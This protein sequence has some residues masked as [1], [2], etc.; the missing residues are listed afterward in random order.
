MRAATGADLSSLLK[1]FRTQAGLSQ[2]MLADRALISVQAVSA[3][4][5]GSR[6]VPYR[7]TLER[8]ADALALSEEARIELEL[9]AKRARGL[10]LEESVVAPPHNLPRQL[11]SFLGRAEV[12]KE[13]VT[14]L[15][16]EPLVS[17]V[18]TGGA[19]K[20]RVAVAVG[21]ALL[22]TFADGVW[23]VD[24]APLSD[25]E[26][27]PQ[28]LASA[29][30]VQESPN[31]PLL[32]TL[33]AYLGQKR[34]LI[35]FDNCEHVMYGT[36]TVVGSLLRGCP[37]LTLLATSREALTLP[38][39]RAYRIPPLAVPREGIPTPEEACRFGAI[40]LFVDRMRAVDS[41][42]VVTTENVEP[43]VDICRR[44][45]GLPLALELAA[46]RTA[47][48]SPSQIRERLDR[49]FDI[50]T[51][52]GAAP[53]P[54]HQTMRA[55][56]DWSY[57][58]LSSQACLLFTRLAI[59]AGGFSLESASAVCCDERLPAA[60]LL[61]LLS[62]LVAQSLIA[63]DFDRGDARYHL[64]EATRQYA[65]QELE[66]HGERTAL[67]ERHLVAFLRV[68]ER[69]DREWYDAPEPSWFRDAEAEVDNFRTALGWSLAERRDLRAGGVLAAAL[70]RVWYSIAPVEGRRWVR[71]AIDSSDNETA[72]DLRARLYIADAELCGS[73][74]EYTAALSA[75]QQALQLCGTLDGLQQA[76]AKQAA[77]SALGGLGRAGEG[78]PLLE[79]AL[80]I[81]QRLDNRRMQALV[82]GDLGTASS[83][84]GDVEGARR[85]YADALAYYEGLN[86]QR[87]AASIAGHLAEV[88]FAAGDAAA[89]LHLAE[90][91]HAAHAAAQNRRAVAN[92]LCNMAAYLIALGCFDDARAYGRQALSVVRDVKQ[93]VLTAYVLQ[94]LAAVAVLRPQPKQRGA[95]A[96]RKRAAMLLGFVDAWLTKLEARR[97]YTERQEYERVM[98]VLSAAISDRLE[99]T[100]AHGAEWT[101]AVAVTVA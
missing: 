32:E 26:F 13:I 50:L 62:S 20:T 15:G 52:N 41:R 21:T 19:G 33:V 55:V 69:L 82:L 48:L 101:E 73:L 97:E 89:A 98:K 22:N 91:A 71:L 94:H 11:T 65:L 45:S 38:G 80:A 36:R 76:R 40:E 24:L 1:R 96:V 7:Y 93:T 74:G 27:V 6:K 92:D 77:G 12:V 31:R 9:S 85:F 67:A 35:V 95:G 18:G 83:R 63:V 53:I 64:L 39:E 44:L 49:I 30:R 8:I 43:I 34:T 25:S 61:A 70:A 23:F 46:A 58:L 10:R 59:F 51:N 28:A 88:E 75:A 100:M 17:I 84:C 81:S 72:H 86:L 37:N 57:G 2:Q 60:D 99:D 5:R 42:A 79:A 54:R 14:L 68:A 3:L 16:Q 4:E 47:V 29:L 87:P 78:R 56:I 90:E 66:Q